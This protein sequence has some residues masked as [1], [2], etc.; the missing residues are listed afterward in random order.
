[1]ILNLKYLN[2][3][4]QYHHFKMEM[5]DSATR[6]MSRDCFM[7]SIDFKDAYYSVPIHLSFQKYLKFMFRDQLYCVTAFANGLAP[8][9]RLFTKLMK[10]VLAELRKNGIMITGFI[11][12]SL[13]VLW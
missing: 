5:L 1:M 9:P 3:S 12:D 10:P 7:A 8:C 11:D 13:L 6:L 4:I 2:E